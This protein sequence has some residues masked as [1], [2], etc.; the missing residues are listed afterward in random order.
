MRNILGPSQRAILEQFAWSRVLIGLDFDGTLAPIVSSPKNARLAR[1][2]HLLVTEVAH[3]YPCVV[4]SGRARADV[5]E[6]L[7]GIP[8]FDV[9]GNHGIEPVVEGDALAAEVVRWMPRLRRELA[10]AS[11]VIIEDKRFSV[12]IHLR[13]SRQKKRVRAAIV[14]QAKALGGVRLIGGKE[15]INLLPRGA[16]HKGLAL[17]A[18]RTRAGCD[19]ALFIGDDDTDEDVFA[20]E[21][22]GRLLAI[23]VGYQ[24]RSLA[25]F[26]VRER[27]AVDELLR[28]LC[29]FRP[30]RPERARLGGPRIGL[31]PGA[32]V[33]G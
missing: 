25:S 4:I 15:V 11:G 19:T 16:P 5:S 23:R 12:A 20:L 10:G 9:V 31:P 6:R 1:R 24:R 27:E 32:I 13:R 8:L 33:P 26:N 21:Q 14:K 3:R 18:V 29:E 30:R 28:L 17:E 2:T 22:P 7:H